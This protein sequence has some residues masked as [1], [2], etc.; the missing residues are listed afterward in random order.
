MEED[1]PDGLSLLLSKAIGLRMFP[2]T[3]IRELVALVS[4]HVEL[5]SSAGTIE[6]ADPLN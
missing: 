4:T 6:V 1:S 3:V 5:S 2:R